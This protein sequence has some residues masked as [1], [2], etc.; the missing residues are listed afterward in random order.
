MTIMINQSEV[1]AM[2]QLPDKVQTLIQLIPQGLSTFNVL[3]NNQNES[4]TFDSAESFIEQLAL[5][6]RNSSLIF[7]PELQLTADIK[8]LLDLSTN[9]LRDLSYLADPKLNQSNSNSLSSAQRKQ[10][11]EKH[12]LLDSGDFSA[13]NTLVKSQNLSTHPLVLSASFDDQITLQQILSY[14]QQTFS[15]TN[16]QMKGAVQWAIKHAQT[17]SEFAHYCCIYLAWQQ[18]ANSNKTAE[19]N[20]ILSQLQPL[21]LDYL[22]CP[23]VTF[24]LDTQTLNMAITQ[25]QDAGNAVGFKSYSEGVMSVVLNIDLANTST[26]NEQVQTYLSSLQTLLAKT[27]SSEQFVGQAGEAQYYLLAQSNRMVVMSVASNGCLSVAS[28]I[29]IGPTVSKSENT[30]PTQNQGGA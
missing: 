10:L 22:Q 28:D 30:E 12:Q 9:D 3:L 27:L 13:V 1:T 2:A 25:W 19:L 16:S 6:L 11:L 18:G 21:I 24:E 8:K 20:T 14:C 15:Y 23:T 4:Y 17:L 26:L 29:A 7:M 5:G